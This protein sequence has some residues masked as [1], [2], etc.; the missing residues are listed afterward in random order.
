MANAITMR[1]DDLEARA[2]EL[3]RQMANLSEEIEQAEEDGEMSVA[4]LLRDE[5][6]ALDDER[7]ECLD[8]WAQLDRY[9]CVPSDGEGYYPSAIEIATGWF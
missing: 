8:E 6:D 1:M 5:Y 7:D 9:G 2:D 3:L 4:A